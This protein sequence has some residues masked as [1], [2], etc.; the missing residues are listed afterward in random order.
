MGRSVNY[1]NNARVIIYFE[2]DWMGQQEDGEINEDIYTMDCEDFISNLQYGI[3]AR[4]KS[5]YI[6]DKNTW[7]NN[8]TKIILQNNL[9]N[10]GISEYCG[11]WSLSVAVKNDY[12]IKEALANNHADKIRNTLEKCI[13]EFDGKVLNRIGTFSNGC[14]VFEYKK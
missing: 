2:A 12:D 6:P 4:L 14:G 10:I 3:K 13:N 9:C 8:E 7:D 11:C 5:Y 1:L